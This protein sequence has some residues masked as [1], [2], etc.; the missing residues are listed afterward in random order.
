M[1]GIGKYAMKRQ[2]SRSGTPARSVAARKVQH[3]SNRRRRTRTLTFGTYRPDALPI[4]L[5]A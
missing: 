2:G 1:L 4:E 3:K 5:S